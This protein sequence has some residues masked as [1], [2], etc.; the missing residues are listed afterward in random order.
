MFPFYTPRKHQKNWGNKS[1]TKL[2]KLLTKAQIGI[3]FC[4]I[5]RLCWKTYALVFWNMYFP[6]F[7]VQIPFRSFRR[8]E[9]LNEKVLS[10]C[11]YSINTQL[12][13]LLIYS[14]NFSIMVFS[15]VHLGLGFDRHNFSTTFKFMSYLHCKVSRSYV[16][17]ER[18]FLESVV[19]TPYCN[20]PKGS[21]EL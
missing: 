14:A 16:K 6:I 3:E 4:C 8:H 15:N 17:F 5:H 20:A 13:D 9:K 10:C 1:T 11:Q 18:K 19:T 12:V 7:Q 2:T 21:D